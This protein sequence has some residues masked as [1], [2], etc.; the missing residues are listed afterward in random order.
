MNIL[1]TWCVLFQ[2][3]II[4]MLTVTYQC[5]DCP[6]AFTVSSHLTVHIRRAHTGEKPYACDACEYSCASSGTLD[7]HKR[8]HTGEKPYACDACEYSC[9]SSSHLTVHMRI[10]TGEKPHKV[11]HGPNMWPRHQSTCIVLVYKSM[12]ILPCDFTVHRM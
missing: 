11:M 10:H 6:K 1:R 5:P 8:T 2:V 4:V 7:Q 3:Y 12:C 9:A